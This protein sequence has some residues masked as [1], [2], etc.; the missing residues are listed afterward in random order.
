LLALLLLNANRVVSV[1][2]LV[3]YLWGDQPPATARG[4]LQGCVAG[5]RRVLRE[6][7]ADGRLETVAPGYLL[8]VAPGELDL[9]RFEELADEASRVQLADPVRAAE[10]FAA[11]LSL[12]RG[13]ALDGILLAG[14]QADVARL[15]ERRLTAL[16]Q[17]IDVDLRLGRHAE[18]VGEL[19]AH[20]KAHPLREGRWAQLMLALHAADRQAD[21]LD[22][23]RQLRQTLVAQLGVEPGTLIQ[24]LHRTILAGGD[25]LP[26]YLG[27]R[28][29][30]VE[31]TGPP[32]PPASPEPVAPAQLPAVPAQLPAAPAAFTGRRQQLKRL[33][34]LLTDSD[35]APR[36]AMVSGMAGAGKTAL[37]VYWAHQV[38]QRF[39]HGQ[40]YTNL[41]GYA[42]PPMRPI[43]ALAGFLQALRVPADRIP[44]DL[45]QAA[46]LYRSL[47][48]DR[49]VLV[50]LDNA[51][52]IEQVRPLLPGGDGCLVL[53][54]SR[55]LFG[56]LVAREGAVHVNL[57][58]LD[59]DE[60]RALL[61]QLLGEERVQAEAPAA[62]ELARLCAFLPL[63]LRIAAAN[64]TLHPRPGIAEQVAELAA[65]DRLAA[66]A[67]SQ[68]EQ[69]AVRTAFDQSYAAL[70]ADARG[71]FRLLGL[72]PGPH[73]TAGA[74]AA[75][76]GTLPGAAARLLRRLE[77]GH[78]LDQPAPDRYTLHDLVRIYAA[79][80]VQ[81]E[82]PADDR[83]AAADRLS[84]WYLRTTEA[85]AQVL[86][87]QLLRL[88]MAHQ[89]GVPADRFETG[90]AAL[91]WLEAERPNLYAMV[92]HT[93]EHGQH[94][95]TH[96]LSHALFGFYWLRMY[97]A[98]WSATAEAGLAAAQAD[99]DPR[100]EA[101]AENDL[102]TA[103]MRQSRHGPAT[104]HY[105]RA[106]AL[107][108]RLGWHEAHVA[109]LNGLGIMYQRQ[110]RMLE[111]AKIHRHALDLR[112]RSGHRRGQFVSLANLGMVYIGLGRLRQAVEALDEALAL[113]REFGSRHREA[114]CLEALG[115]VYYL[116][117]RF[118]ESEDH[119][120][121]ALPTLREFGERAVEAETLRTLAALHCDAGR[122]APALEAAEAAVALAR[123]GGELALEPGTLVVLGTVE[124]RLGRYSP[125]LAQ[126]EQALRLALDTE[127]RSVVVEALMGVAAAQHRLD[128]IAEA[129][130]AVERAVELATAGDFRVL[131]GDAFVA[132]A[133]VEAA[134]GRL[135]EAV[136]YAERAAALQRE[137]G[138]RLG[139]AR[140]LRELGQALHD[141]GETEAAVASLRQAYARFSEIGS[142]EAEQLRA[143][144]PDR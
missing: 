130:H 129:R 60:A 82:E 107:S 42:R 134:A 123:D 71:L 115:E 24:Q 52:S 83:R 143:R 1:D 3:D 109:T 126:H 106:L 20:V 56:G 64:L 85:A 12:W 44:V 61:A 8:R 113:A 59:P 78:L 67:V 34:E 120:T 54:T 102:A 97:P 144:L 46:A 37:A 19:Y 125:A 131:M 9:D 99:G 80:R 114:H 14:C 84:D 98:E 4:L 27:T 101:L 66:L 128:R 81:Q 93:A 30:P 50:V 11:A 108:E 18:L 140:A 90:A 41:R 133:A 15:E 124:H 17:R 72:V 95:V 110:Q 53:V 55:E 121:S 26:D 35:R 70:P 33:D 22:A 92:Q 10:L 122:Y 116:L 111:A 62:A 57:G 136:A 13:P 132:F 100:A 103:H 139:E 76:A 45:E 74:A 138:H 47:L 32:P 31:R 137:T 105:H 88:P 135:G 96:R 49:Q 6:A 38:R 75:L 51:Y 39:P 112:R 7:A 73:V 48:A 87:P 119:L 58:V 69:A 79:D 25:P 65:G 94:Q 141:R 89:S 40:L 23:Y 68:D 36:V 86:H 91:A 77:G 29:L 142:P 117:G 118:R 5:L 2:R 16:A 43:D 28:G 63:A 104:D 21:A 127:Q